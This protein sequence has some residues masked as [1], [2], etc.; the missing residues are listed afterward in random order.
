LDQDREFT[1]I[2][3]GRY[4]WEPVM[5]AHPVSKPSVKLV[6]LVMA[7]YAN[8]RTG[9][10]VRPGVARLVADTGTSRNV[11]LRALAELKDL[12]LIDQ[13][14]RG[15]N[16]G[17]ASKGM[18]SIYQLT[19]PS[20][21]SEFLNLT[22]PDD[23]EEVPPLGHDP[24]EE[25]PAVGHVDR[26]QVPELQEQVPIESGTGPKIDGTGPGTGTLPLQSHPSNETPLQNHP[27]SVAQAD[28]HEEQGEIDLDLPA[29][30]PPLSKAALE[31]QWAEEFIEWYEAYPKRV[32]RGA[33]TGAFLK[34]RKNGA[35]LEDLM[36]GARRY[37]AERKGEDP[38]FTAHPV[39]WLNQ[40]RWADDP[41]HMGEIDVG[42]ILGK[43]YWTPGTP[44]EGLSVS[45][46]IGWKKEQR[47][48][49]NAERLAEAKAKAAA[50]PLSPWDP[51]YHQGGKPTTSQK[52]QN[53][54]A[55]GIRLQALADA[56][57]VPRQ[58]AWCNTPNEIEPPQEESA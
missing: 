33:A 52:M 24:F 25:V 45:E 41:T 34:A 22:T 54:M 19:V 2:P 17:R 9:G 4:E 43:D 30:K 26:E 10:Q 57:N 3:R 39:T 44:P 15:G 51:A 11:V 36:A 13:L 5:R 35:T 56:R 42:V 28:A 32:G 20:D 7:T 49:H 31:K 53:T 23:Q 8:T 58:Y 27:Q 21:L 38:K 46:E 40:E 18:A 12:G 48:L 6:A 50:R 29:K 55:A 1:R 37:A 47:A 14:T 16:L